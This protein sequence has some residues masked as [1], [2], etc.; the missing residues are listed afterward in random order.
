[1]ARGR[2][3]LSDPPIEWK[4]SL[5]SSV[6]AQIELHLLDPLSGKP[7]HGARSKLITRLLR[8][9]IKSQQLQGTN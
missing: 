5:P 7:K 2:P 3:Q 4:I 6:A 9:W 8:T 1:M